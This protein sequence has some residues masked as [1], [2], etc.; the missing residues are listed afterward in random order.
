MRSHPH[1]SQLLTPHDD[2]YDYLDMALV[3]AAT[4]YSWLTV[5]EC[6]AVAFRA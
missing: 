6:A 4:F 3:H 5:V 1:N 2:F